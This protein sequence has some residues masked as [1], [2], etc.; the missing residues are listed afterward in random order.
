MET[1]AKPRTQTVE[2]SESRTSGPIRRA[3][4]RREPVLWAALV[5]LVATGEWPAVKRWVSGDTALPS[6]AA[7]AAGT[8]RQTVDAP[9]PVHSQPLAAAPAARAAQ[10]GSGISW[11]TSYA[12]ALAEARASRKYVLVDFYAS[13]CPPCLAMKHEVWPAPEVVDA[14]NA[15]YVPLVVDTDQNPSLS[16]RYQVESLP[17]VVLLDADGRVVKR[18]TGYLPRSGV[19]RFLA[20]SGL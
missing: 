2:P 6:A 1:V 5:L 15:R 10:P 14:V 12:S 8:V 7:P 20:E 17:S 18:H 16:A 3:W 13:W 4:G 11:R 9:E 19:L